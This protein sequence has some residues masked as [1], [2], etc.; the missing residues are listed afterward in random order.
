MPFVKGKSGNPSGVSKARKAFDALLDELEPDAFQTL[1][2]LL[3]NED[4]RVRLDALKIYLERRFGKPK[5]EIEL[6]GA[7]SV[8]MGLIILPPEDNPPD[9]VAGESGPAEPIPSE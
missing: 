1:R 5:Q 3:R 2:D 4:N 7:V 9:A 6:D 8:S